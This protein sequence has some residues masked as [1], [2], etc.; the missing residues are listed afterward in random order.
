MFQLNGKSV[1]GHMGAVFTTNAG[2]FIHI[3][4]PF[5]QLSPQ[6]RF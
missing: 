6:L 5:P 2:Y 4:P 1:G 3:N